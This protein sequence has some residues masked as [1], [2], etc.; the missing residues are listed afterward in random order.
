MR[1][2]DQAQHQDR[3]IHSDKQEWL[4]QLWQIPKVKFICQPLCPVDVKFDGNE[5]G[6]DWVLGSGHDEV[7]TSSLT[8]I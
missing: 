6:L 2:Q 1:G 5:S 3:M 4:A 8:F 7:R